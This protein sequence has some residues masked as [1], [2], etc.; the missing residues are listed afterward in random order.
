VVPEAGI[1]LTKP[2]EA[3]NIHIHPATWGW[4]Y[5]PPLTEDGNTIY[6]P[7]YLRLGIYSPDYLRLGMYIFTRLPEAWTVFS[8]LQ[9]KEMYSIQYSSW[10]WEYIHPYYRRLGTYSFTFTLRLSDIYIYIHPSFQDLETIY[11]GFQRLAAPPP[12]TFS[13]AIASGLF[14]IPAD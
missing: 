9:R 14:S 3:G 8:R 7:D 12:P 1:I 13:P 10:G 2:P 6:S 4:E 5:I 11:V